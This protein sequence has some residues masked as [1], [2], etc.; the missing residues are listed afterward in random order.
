MGVFKTLRKRQKYI[1]YFM[2]KD[3]KELSW[4]AVAT[5]TP[6]LWAKYVKIEEDDGRRLEK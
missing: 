5:M 2:L 6:E 3:V 4:E 1:T